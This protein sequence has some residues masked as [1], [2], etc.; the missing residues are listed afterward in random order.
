MFLWFLE[1]CMDH[2]VQQ[3][4]PVLLNLKSQRMTIHSTLYFMLMDPKI[5]IVLRN[6]LMGNG[7]SASDYKRCN[8]IGA[9]E[10]DDNVVEEVDRMQT[11]CASFTERM[12][13][14]PS[15]YL[16]S[17]KKT[18]DRLRNSFSSLPYG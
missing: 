5:D 4:L 18:L 7:S 10:E 13:Q 9:S 6:G 11:Y 15:L 1:K 16:A 14:G 8:H 12:D 3:K 17:E 2:P